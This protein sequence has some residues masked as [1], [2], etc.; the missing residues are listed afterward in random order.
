MRGYS[1]RNHRYDSCEMRWFCVLHNCLV[2]ADMSTARPVRNRRPSQKLFEQNDSDAESSEETE[3]GSDNEDEEAGKAQSA[4]ESR[5]RGK[6][7][8]HACSTV[9]M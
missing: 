6:C 9:L 4:A 5:K 7:T 1:A 2:S 3:N 8:R